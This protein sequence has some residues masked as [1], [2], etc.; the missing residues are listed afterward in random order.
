VKMVEA[1]AAKQC[2]SPALAVP[3]SPPNFDAL[4][5][6]IGAQTNAIAAQANY[7]T[8]GS[9]ILAV[10]A[11]VA[12]VG[13]GWLVKRWA[14]EAA[15]DAVKKWMEQNAPGQMAAILNTL[16]PP[17]IDGGAQTSASPMTQEEIEKGFGGEA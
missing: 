8:L 14:E 6:S 17:R 3:Q 15:R 7:L 16:T 4:A 5:V 1:V 13:W 9:I 2:V 12:A 11:I 10:I